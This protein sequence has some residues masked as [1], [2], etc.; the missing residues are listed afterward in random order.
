M[1]GGRS[2][3]TGCARNGFYGATYIVDRRPSTF[4]DVSSFPFLS[5]AFPRQPVTRSTARDQA[6]HFLDYILHSNDN[7]KKVPRRMVES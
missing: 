5:R 6:S 7:V 1:L 3:L 2:A 4:S